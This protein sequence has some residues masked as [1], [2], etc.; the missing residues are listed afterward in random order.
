MRPDQ[1]RRILIWDPFKKT[2]NNKQT[3]YPFT[4]LTHM[5]RRVARRKLSTP[6]KTVTCI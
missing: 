1:T 5:K 2:T 6:P 4:V 3:L